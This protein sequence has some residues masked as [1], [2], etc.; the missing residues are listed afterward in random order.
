L[1]VAGTIAWNTIPS[2]PMLPEMS[3]S[4]GSERGKLIYVSSI[5]NM[6]FP[7]SMYLSVLGFYFSQQISQVGRCDKKIYPPR[8]SE[9][10]CLSYCYNFIKH[11]T[12]KKS[13][14]NRREQHFYLLYLIKRRF[15]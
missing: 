2:S 5:R 4:G 12:F 15:F 1:M 11:L 8:K 14:N 13:L 9:S 3:A 6:K 10:A 7:L